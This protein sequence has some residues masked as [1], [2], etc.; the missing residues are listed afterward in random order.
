MKHNL[1]TVQLVI[2]NGCDII[3][4]GCYYD[5]PT[6]EGLVNFAKNSNA[7]ITIKNTPTARLE[8]LHHLSERYPK[9]LIIDFT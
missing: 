1:E 4:E 3:I 5:D 6:L 7:K 8:I 2:S 9:N